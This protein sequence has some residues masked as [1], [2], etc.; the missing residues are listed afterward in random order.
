MKIN[1]LSECFL[2]EKSDFKHLFKIMRICLIILFAFT[3]QLIATNTNAQNAIIELKSNSITISQL[4]NEIEKQTDYLVVYSNRELNTS[5]TVNLKN[6]SD[7]VSAYLIEAFSGTDIGYNFENNY[8]V[9]SKK[10]ADDKPIEKIETITLQQQGKT[11]TGKIVDA[12]GE[13]VIGATIQIKGTGQGTVTDIDG[14]YTLSNVPD[15]AILDISYVGMQPQSIPL[16]G[17]TSINITLLQDTELLEEVIVVGYT[18]QRRESLTGSLQSISDKKLKNITT[19]SVENMLNGKAP[20]VYVAPGSGQPGQTGTIIIRG[21]STV[22]G[23][24]DPLWVIDGVIVGNSSGS[25]NPADIATMTILKDAASTAI[26]GSQGANGVIV[27]T[28]KNPQVDKLN[29]SLSAKAGVSNLVKG[30]LQVMNGAELYDYFSSFSNPEEVIFPRWNPELRNSNFNWWDHASQTGFIQEYNLSLS[31]GSEK[32]R[33]LVSIGVYDETGSVKGYEFTRYNLL[34]KTDYRPFNWLTIKPFISGSRRNIDDRQHSVSAMYSALPWDS[35][36]DKD[37]KIVGHRSPLWVN[38]NSTNYMYDRQWN[39]AKSTTYEFMGNLDFDIKL[40]DWLTFSSVN[41]IKYIGGNYKA[42]DDPRSSSAEG[43]QGRISEYR[44]E[45]TRLYTN[46]LLRFNKFWDKHSVN[47]LLAYEFN[48]YSGSSLDVAGIGFVPGFEILDVT[49]KPE[50]TKGGI[51]EW[52]VQSVFSNINYAYD[53]KYLAQLSL[54]R[55]GASNFGD[56]A[57][58]GNFFSISAGWNIHR[59]AFFK[60]DIVNELKLRASYGSVGNRP[61]ALYPQYDL[62]AVSSSVSYN[63]N[64]GALISQIGNKNLTWEKSY[65][66]GIG[67]DAALYDRFR[68]TFDYYD[69]NT[70]DLLY[71]VPVSGLTGVTRVWRNVGAVRNK[72]FE[73]TASIDVIKNK[74]LLWTIDGNIG[75]NRNKVT[76]LFGERDPQT[77]EVAPIIGGSGVNISGAA[78]TILRE[79]I[80]A[81][82]WFI[83][84]WA[85]VNPENGAPQWYKTVTDANGNKTREITEKHSEA[86]LVE[87]GSYTPKFFGGFST[88]LFWK[89]FDANMVFGYSVGGKI[90][91]YT[92][93]EYDSDGTYSD[94]NQMRL[95]PSWSR[96]KKPGDIA[97]H[98]V[99]KYENSSGSNKTS[100]RF[101]EDGSYLKMRSL[102]LGYNLEL[103]QYHLQNVRLFITGENLFTITNYSGVD[104]EL[105]TYEDAGGRR[106]VGV[107][108]TVYPSTRKFLFGVNVTF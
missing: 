85:G 17:K 42:Y 69:K 45:A 12:S 18:T 51:A 88:S 68:F 38:S 34:Y 31:G 6:K 76:E 54:R 11:V 59:E 35:P 53:N 87:L 27:V 63:E 7:K 29:I 2:I 104:P 95:L 102:S 100:S 77:G 58:Y 19:P 80:E 50:K 70:S 20:G 94:R 9:L 28:T 79:G 93:L 108:T 106:V 14:N 66:A 101:L 46:Q 24:T 99:A 30:N 22:N 78:S 10:A 103:P 39:F 98:P 37:G 97:T 72:G 61:T 4:L 44:S 75:L 65:T 73:A 25:L 43:V 1:S 36:Y 5:R 89:Q 105:P 92:R 33:S 23:S 48:D 49:A 67:L 83:Q 15:D 56:N 91:N 41:N 62:Y 32:L 74:D 64:S 16:D 60:N 84:E 40:T 21:K 81:D 71:Q 55:D 13:P 57:K 82:T 96:W 107:T 47:A 86:D 52:A 90:F 3:F 26:Y 8:I